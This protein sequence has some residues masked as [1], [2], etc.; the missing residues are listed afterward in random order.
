[1]E[2]ESYVFNCAA[3]SCCGVCAMG[4]YLDTFQIVP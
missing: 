2:E 3:H 1:M 4:H